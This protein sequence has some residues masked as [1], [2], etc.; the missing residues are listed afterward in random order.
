MRTLALLGCLVVGLPAI[1]GC[2]RGSEAAE[3]Q[4]ADGST[5]GLPDGD[6][7]LAKRLVAEGALLL[8]VRTPA[9]FASRH[10]DGAKNVPVDALADGVDEIAALVADE[11]TP[12]VVYCRSGARSARAKKHLVAA[13]YRQVTNLGSIDDWTE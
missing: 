11:N 12:I 9:E 6:P 5:D 4:L 13:G 2:A 3:R 10:L 8:D 1:S 7:V